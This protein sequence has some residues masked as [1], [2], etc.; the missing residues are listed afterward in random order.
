MCGVATALTMKSH[1]SAVTE[2]QRQRR[3]DGRSGSGNDYKSVS[4]FPAPREVEERVR[5]RS[6]VRFVN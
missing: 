4:I 1:W 2:Y 6:T 3:V 5:L